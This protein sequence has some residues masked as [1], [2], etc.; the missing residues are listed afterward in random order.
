MGFADSG[1]H[2]RN[3]AFYNFPIRLLKRVNEAQKAGAPFLSPE[4]AVHRLTGELAAFYGLD[5]G[6]LR[7]GSR[8]DL[9]VVDPNGLDDSVD[10]YYE[11]PIEPFGGLMRMVNRSDSAVHTTLVGGQV[12]FEDGQIVGRGRTGRFLRAGESAGTV[13]ERLLCA[14]T[15]G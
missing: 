13:D 11:A 12:V 8:A 10:A 6:V 1:A 14:R 15:R 5:A 9:V 4:R 7:Q 3:M 2:L